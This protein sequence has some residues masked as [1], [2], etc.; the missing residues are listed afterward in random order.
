MSRP[1]NVV[2]GDSHITEPTNLW[3]DYIDPK[4]RDTCPKIWIEADGREVFR[5]DDRLTFSDYPQ[6]KKLSIAA[7]TLF[8]AR[9]ALMPEGSNYFDG[10]KGGFDPHARIAWMDAEGIDGSVVFP[11]MALV[12][13]HAMIDPDRSIAVSNAYNRWLADFC[14]P[15]PDRFLAVA[16]LPMLSVAG[17]IKEIEHAKKLG[18]N[19]GLVR[20]N[21]VGKRTLHHPDFYPI[22]AVCQDMDFAIAVHGSSGQENIGM[23][24]FGALSDLA[25]L[26]G[27]TTLNTNPSFAVEH[28]Y[29]HTAEM[30]AAVTSFVMAGV[31]DKFPQLRVAFIEAGGGWIPSYIERM[32][33]HFDDVTLNDTGLLTRPSEIFARQCFLQFEPTELT[34]KFLAEYIGPEKIM[35]GSDYPHSD[36]FPGSVKMI[37]EMHMKPDVEA[38]VLGV[39]AKS[40]YGLC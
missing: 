21:P 33:R 28:T 30:M 4:Y 3:D 25:K 1:L 7:S 2:D 20:P 26:Q 31:C 24:R 14:K 23:E 19:A 17:T 35:W 8:G 5:I 29:V 9:N 34:L 11:T 13:G 39:G 10:E 27:V 22:W 38:A 16:S 36:G 18:F 15:Y 37:K 32:D 12:C 6:P 40:W